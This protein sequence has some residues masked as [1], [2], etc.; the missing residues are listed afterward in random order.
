[1]KEYALEDA[2]AFKNFLQI[3]INQSAELTKRV[4]PRIEEE[5]TFFKKPVPVGLRVVLTL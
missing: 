2:T 4:G 1:M 5:D 3:D